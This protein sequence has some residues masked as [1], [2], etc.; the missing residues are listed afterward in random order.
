VANNQ[1]NYIYVIES[2][3]LSDGTIIAFLK[4]ENG[5]LS[6]QSILEDKAGHQWKIKCY[7]WTTGS[8]ESYVKIKSEEAQN[9]FQYLLEGININEKPTKAAR[10]KIL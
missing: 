10:L 2:Y 9:I 3:K 6:D 1:K 4:S 5:K 7:F 8:P